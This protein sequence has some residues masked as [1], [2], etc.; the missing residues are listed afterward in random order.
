VAQFFHEAWS[1]E[2]HPFKVRHILEVI[3]EYIR[4]GRITVRPGAITEPITY[5]D[6]CQVGRNGG[7]FEEPRRIVEGIAADFLDLSPNRAEQW[8]CGGG[9]GTVALTAM[10]DMRIRSG[11]RKVEQIR[12]TGAKIIAS[13]CENCRLQMEDLVEHHGLDL[14]VKAVMDLVVEAM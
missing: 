2:K 7:V 3:D 10:R 13:P 1:G 11:D 9:G 8:C 4:D 14:E 6:P 12:A 5:H